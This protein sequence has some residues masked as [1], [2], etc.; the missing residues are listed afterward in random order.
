M[1]AMPFAML[2]QE[3]RGINLDEPIRIPILIDKK[4]CISIGELFRDS[5]RTRHILWRMHYLDGCK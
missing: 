1:A 4:A 3:I 5:K 2:I